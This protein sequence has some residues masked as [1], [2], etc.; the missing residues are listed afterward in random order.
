M[1]LKKIILNGFKS[2]ADKTEFSF[3]APITAIV[4]PDGCGKSTLA[5]LIAG[6]IKPGKGTISQPSTSLLLQQEIILYLS[7]LIKFAEYRKIF[8][9]AFI[10]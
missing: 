5:K 1:R 8:K 9:I 7:D 2:F 10:R 3:D 6:L 4:G